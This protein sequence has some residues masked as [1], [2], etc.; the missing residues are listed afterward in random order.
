M[1]RYERRRGDEV[2]D[3]TV[4]RDGN[5]DQSSEIQN[6]R[7]Q[8]NES[9]ISS[10]QHELEATK[11]KLETAKLQLELNAMKQK[12]DA[13]REQLAVQTKKALENHVASERKHQDLRNELYVMHD[14]RDDFINTAYA[15][16]RTLAK[17]IKDGFYTADPDNLKSLERD[18]AETYEEWAGCKAGRSWRGA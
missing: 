8:L 10:L 16:F 7:T 14:E 13:T 17:R 12:L 4:G 18:I 9:K 6:L 2:D 5:A 15:I 11:Q 3:Y 1:S